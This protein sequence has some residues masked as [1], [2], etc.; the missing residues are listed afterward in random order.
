MIVSPHLSDEERRLAALADH[1]LIGWSGDGRFDRIVNFIAELC[2]APIALVSLVER[3]EQRF[4]GRYGLDVCST[5]R[6][7][8]FCAHAMLGNEIMV[9]PDATDDPRFADNALVLG[10]PGIRFY[11]GAPLVTASGVMLGAL[12]V[13][14]RVPRAGLTPLQAHGLTALAAEVIAVVEGHQAMEQ[15]NL[16]LREMHHRIKNLFAMTTSLVHFAKGDDVAALRDDLTRRLAALARAHDLVVPSADSPRAAVY[17]LRALCEAVAGGFGGERFVIS[18]DAAGVEQD[19]LTPLAL[20]LHELVTNAAKY[21]ALAN[22]Q[23]RIEINVAKGEHAV[24][25]WREI[26]GRK[27]DESKLVP[28]FGS[29]LIES[30][31]LRQLDARL[32]REW[33]DDGLKLTLTLHRAVR[34]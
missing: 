24:L 30:A 16:L 33:L 31:A 15:R 25:H 32:E 29:R 19:A 34:D 22:P 13:I 18:G 3:E 23:G 12:C 28:G 10:D 27:P 1:G 26:G 9:V 2:E 5:A 14:D 6:S 11:A 7:S 17:D 8:S 21:G 4:L 20:I